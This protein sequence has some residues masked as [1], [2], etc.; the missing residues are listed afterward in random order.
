MRK[1]KQASANKE[2]SV[3]IF[4]VEGRSDENALRNWLED[5]CDTLQIE[6]RV[7]GTDPFTNPE[8]RRKNPETV[9]EEM[10]K[11]ELI[12][13]HFSED[14]LAMIV[15]I[16]DTDGVYIYESAVIVSEE[17]IEKMYYTDDN[18]VVKN[19]GQKKE[20]AR[21]R[22]RVKRNGLNRLSLIKEITGVNYKILYFSRNLEHITHDD[23]DMCNNDKEEEADKFS[24]RF[25]SVS[26]FKE[27]FQ[28]SNFAVDGS[29]E[30]TWKY[31]QQNARSLKRYSNFHLIFDFLASITTIV[32]EK[33]RE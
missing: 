19:E 15:Q 31:I 22:N 5:I 7:V 10:V 33:Q 11:K 23:P 25:Q 1:K 14:D 6:F 8:N 12:R 18:I 29:Y 30:D 17:R 32:G 21:E 28:N 3:V 24:D 13:G 26:E 2:S 20:I 16:T 4:I 9:I 27:F